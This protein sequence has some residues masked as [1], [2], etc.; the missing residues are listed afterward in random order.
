MSTF[1]DC[2]RNP[3]LKYCTNCKTLWR[4]KNES[5]YRADSGASRGLCER[6]VYVF[7]TDNH[8]RQLSMPTTA[9]LDSHFSPKT[10]RRMEI[11][12]LD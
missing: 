10:T 7:R 4:A 2:E 5:K 11:I 8:P 3:M 12:V 6:I 1:R 9:G